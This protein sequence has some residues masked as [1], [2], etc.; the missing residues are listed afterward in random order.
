[1]NGTAIHHYLAEYH[2]REASNNTPWL[3]EQGLAALEKFRNNGL[4]TTRQEN[5]KYTDI[6]ALARTGFITADARHNTIE[7]HRLDAVRIKGLDCYE[8]IFINGQFSPTHTRLEGLP[9]GVMVESLGRSLPNPSATVREHLNRYAD[10]DNYAFT[11]LNTAFLT[12]GTLLVIPANAVIEKPVNLLY[13]SNRQ[14]QTLVSHP[15]NLVILGANSRATLI[16]S[17]IGLD[18]AEYFTNTVTEIL[19]GEGASL[20]HYKIQQESER[21]FHIG[22]T[23]VTQQKDSRYVSHS[24]SL[25]G[26]LVRNDITATL[27]GNGSET[28]LNGL[29]MAGD[30]QHVDNHTLVNHLQPN[31]RSEEYYRGVLDGHARG[32]FNG[33]IIV[34]KNAQKTDARQSNANLLLSDNAEVDTK[35]E[36]EIYAND[37]KCSHGATVGQLDENM[38]FYLRSRAIDEETA[39]SL[40]TYAFADDVIRRITLQPVRDRLEYSVIGR[41]PDASLIREFV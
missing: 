13:I 38:L 3:Q 19:A 5:W 28:I 7:H 27:G 30:R 29:Y 34:H 1:M 26:A 9:A 22:S 41:L 25:G 40:L 37:V 35:P 17:Y 4:P 15:R 10:N 24:I 2:R 12:D 8:L 23:H 14:D 18:K 21:S 32:V 31:T 39:R 33:K 36:L 11:A 20:E 6:G 16:E